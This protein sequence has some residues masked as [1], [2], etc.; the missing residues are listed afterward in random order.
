[1]R[2]ANLF[3]ANLIEADLRYAYLTGA[4]VVGAI[5]IKRWLKKV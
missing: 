4:N 5:G 2:Y 1:M 3:R